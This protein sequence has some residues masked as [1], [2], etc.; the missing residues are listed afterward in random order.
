MLPHVFGQKTRRLALVEI[1][2]AEPG[3]ALER[4]SQVGLNEDLAHVIIL[5]ALL[6]DT[7]RLGKLRQS[8]RAA[9]RLRLRIRKRKALG[10]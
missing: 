1:R 3:N 9:Q 5:A 2:G 10:G 7:A 6:K 8:A 4:P